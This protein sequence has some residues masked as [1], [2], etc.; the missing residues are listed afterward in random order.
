MTVFEEVRDFISKRSPDAVCDDC[1]A[2]YLNLSV[3]Q[4][5]N[6]KTRKLAVVRG[7]VRQKDVC[8]ICGA[9]KKVIRHTLGTQRNN[10]GFRIMIPTKAE[11]VALEDAVWQAL[12][13]GDADGDARLLSDD[14][15]GV[16]D[17]GFSA[18]SDHVGQVAD[19]PSVQDYRLSDIRLHLARDGLA[20]LCYRAD[21]TRTG[22]TSPEVMYVSSLWQ[23]TPQGWRNSFSQ[24]TAADT[25]AA[26]AAATD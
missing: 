8:S 22:A 9:N 7:F 20:L 1:I 10:L 6:H 18:K 11:I 14:F 19:G 15:L 17:S 3:R 21:Y 16:Y 24:D 23:Q 13:S 12:V 25:T 5:A 2:D 26:T 4:H